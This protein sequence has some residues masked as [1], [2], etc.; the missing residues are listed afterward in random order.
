M[1][2][3]EIL[4]APEKCGRR[5]TPF[6][7][8]T[9]VNVAIEN[10]LKHGHFITVIDDSGRWTNCL[11]K[12]CPHLNNKNWIIKSEAEKEWNSLNCLIAFTPKKAERKQYLSKVLN[13]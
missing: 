12:E 6:K 3:G 1:R 10:S 7:E 2:L 11:E 4:I 8:Y 5:F 13:K 9:V